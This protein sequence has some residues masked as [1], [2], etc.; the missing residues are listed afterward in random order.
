MLRHVSNLDAVWDEIA[1]TIERAAIKLK[2]YVDIPDIRQE[3]E[4]KKAALFLIDGGGFLVARH[5]HEGPLSIL[6]VWM[7]HSDDL[8]GRLPQLV[9]EVDRM[10]RAMGCS[11]VR[12]QSPRKAWKRLPWF[13][14]VSATYERKVS[15]V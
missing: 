13:R 2:Q 5:L 9:D 15:D 8:C 14:E 12:F 11:L 6:F 3:I 7:V 1:A 10:A 4:Q